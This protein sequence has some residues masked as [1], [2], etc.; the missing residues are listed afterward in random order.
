MITRKVKVNE[1][2]VTE[3]VQKGQGARDESFKRLLWFAVH[4][5][6]LFYKN[7][8]ALPLVGSWK[9]IWTIMFY[10]M[11]LGT[12]AIEHSIMFDLINEGLKCKSHM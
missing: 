5:P 9:D 4:Q 3:K 7:I 10:D 6:D 11:V 1:S 8:W 2:S 12:N